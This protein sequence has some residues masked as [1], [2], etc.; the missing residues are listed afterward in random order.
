MAMAGNEGVSAAA[1]ADG[2]FGVA[3]GRPIATQQAAQAL[4]LNACSGVPSSGTSVGDA[5]AALKLS[6]L[7]S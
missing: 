3:A 2:S 1:G 7:M 6:A 4:H 5:G